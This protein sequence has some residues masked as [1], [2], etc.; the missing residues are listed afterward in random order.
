MNM[1]RFV[2]TQMKSN[3][4]EELF[5]RYWKLLTI[6]VLDTLGITFLSQGVWFVTFFLHLGT[7]SGVLNFYCVMFKAQT[8][9]SV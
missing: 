7:W 9:G 8:A 6:L 3:A 5:L 1:K 4:L 2:P